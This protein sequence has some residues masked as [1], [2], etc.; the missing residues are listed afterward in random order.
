MEERQRGMFA[1]LSST[2]VSRGSSLVSS[3]ITT[4]TECG[5][6]NDPGCVGLGAG[7]RKSPTPRPTSWPHPPARGP[8]PSRRR[9][10]APPPVR[11]RDG[12][13]GPGAGAGAQGAGVPE[14]RARVEP[15]AV[16]EP[17]VTGLSGVGSVLGEHVA[18]QERRRR[19]RGRLHVPARRSEGREGRERRGAVVPSSVRGRRAREAAV[20]RGRAPVHW[21]GPGRVS[22]RRLRCGHLTPAA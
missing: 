10:P 20:P 5:R 1:R 8:R 15:P 3:S 17:L 6:P 11:P 18:G 2:S 13:V 12:G 4:Q 22:G 14:W 16:H 9:P 19:L 21:G 7:Q